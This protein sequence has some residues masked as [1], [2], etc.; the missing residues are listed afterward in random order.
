ML[1]MGFGII[2]GR[3]GTEP[4]TAATDANYEPNDSYT[5]AIEIQS[6]LI[7]NLGVNSTDQIDW[8]RIKISSKQN[9]FIQMNATY[10]FYFTTLELYNTLNESIYS[11]DGN[12]HERN[13]TKFITTTGYYYIRVQIRPDGEIHYSLLVNTTAA[14]NYDFIPVIIIVVVT[15]ACVSIILI[16]EVRARSTK[17]RNAQASLMKN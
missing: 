15:S 8:F 3:C 14:N 16:V 5:Q 2:D 10:S 17:K 11:S 12:V 13:V 1:M 9:L 7:T 6:G 4:Q